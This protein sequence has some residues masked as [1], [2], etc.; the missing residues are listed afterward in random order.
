MDSQQ[1]VAQSRAQ[2]RT[3]LMVGRHA[4]LCCMTILMLFSLAV[5]H[6]AAQQDSSQPPAPRVKVGEITATPGSSAMVPVYF[7]PDP[8]TAVRSFTVEIEHVSNNLKFQTAS[9]GAVEGLEL[10]ST[11]DNGTPDDKGVMRSKLRFTVSLA[12]KKSK[13]GLPEG[14][15]AFLMF[16][17]AQDAKPF[18]I[19]LNLTVLSAED[20][21]SPSRKISNVSVEPGSVAVTSSDVEP[22]MTC[23]F[24]S[25]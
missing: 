1:D 16:Q 14:L 8:K 21:Q 5:R 13:K 17:L 19:K 2:N 20:T 6:A 24:F 12:D 7:T 15:V 18:V 9:D 10:S 3:V 11:V 23:F 25:H 4:F 22:G